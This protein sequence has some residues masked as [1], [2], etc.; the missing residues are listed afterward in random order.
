MTQILSQPD[1]GGHG[2][3]QWRR[4]TQDPMCSEGLQTVGPAHGTVSCKSHI[5]EME[6][7]RINS[8]L[9]DVLTAVNIRVV[10]SLMTRAEMVLETLAYSP[11]SNLTYLLA[12]EHFHSF[13]L[14]PF[15]VYTNV[16]DMQPQSFTLKMKAVCSSQTLVL[17]YQ[18][19][20]R[21]NSRAP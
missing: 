17:S 14:P 4:K 12:R 1:S 9:R 20:R 19:R 21:H 18:N 8:V 2:H 3:G 6:R 15:G 16:T 7:Q 10:S 5:H 13:I 11:L